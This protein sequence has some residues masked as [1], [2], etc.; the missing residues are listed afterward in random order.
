MTNQFVLLCPNSGNNAANQ[1]IADS[2][3]QFSVFDPFVAY[4]P[5]LSPT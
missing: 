2:P 3:N 4:A 1:Q 5:L